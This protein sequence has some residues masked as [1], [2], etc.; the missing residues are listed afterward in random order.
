MNVQV[1]PHALLI[2]RLAE[3]SITQEELSKKIGMAPSTLNLKLSGKS[4]FTVK[5]INKI[6]NELKIEPEN[7]HSYFF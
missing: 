4:E 7:L 5:E 3:N 2:G 6:C 1:R